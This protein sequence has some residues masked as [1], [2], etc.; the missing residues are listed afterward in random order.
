VNFR[1]HA[2][3]VSRTLGGYRLTL[4]TFLSQNL[5]GVV[6][7]LEVLLQTTST[8]PLKKVKI[9]FI[10]VNFNLCSD[11][12]EGDLQ[13]VSDNTIV[14]HGMGGRFAHHPQD[15]R[16]SGQSSTFQ[17]ILEGGEE[18]WTV[19]G[20]ERA[21]RP[22]NQCRKFLNSSWKRVLELEVDRPRD[23][24]SARTFPRNSHTTN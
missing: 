12:R 14:V 9:S 17:V 24:L 16:P 3:K 10:R 22:G 4:D 7:V 2:Q 6:L 8:W 5:R 19:D 11:S 13:Q 20:P 1:H 15:T 21:P 23:V 18:R